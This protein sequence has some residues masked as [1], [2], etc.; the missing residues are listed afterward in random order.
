[1]GSTRRG[2]A[3]HSGVGT[4]LCFVADSTCVVEP[5]SR[6]GLRRLVPQEFNNPDT[7]AT[8]SIRLRLDINHCLSDVIVT[9]SV[10]HDCM[11]Q[12]PVPRA[13]VGVVVAAIPMFRCGRGSR[14]VP[15][16]S[17]GVPGPAVP[18]R[19]LARYSPCRSTHR[20]AG[21][22]TASWWLTPFRIVPARQTGIRRCRS[23]LLAG[24]PRRCPL[25][26]R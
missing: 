18:L 4:R 10:F 12:Q 7:R 1:M 20:S 24:H 16:Y 17:V 22:L 21:P 13:L 3:P 8:A 11:I 2:A 25:G 26:S 9:C 5:G 6:E 19:H 23:A 15:R 14:P